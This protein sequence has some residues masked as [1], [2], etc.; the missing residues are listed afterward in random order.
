[1]S[2]NAFI[3]NYSLPQP[4]SKEPSK[5]RNILLQAEIFSTFFVESFSCFTV[6]P[7]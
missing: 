3:I 2:L 4:P 7:L 6:L 5:K 1:M